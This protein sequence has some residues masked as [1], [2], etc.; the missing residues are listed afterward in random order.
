MSA[1]ML[2]MGGEETGGTT[3]STGP[4]GPTG[5]SGP[6]LEYIVADESHVFPAQAGYRELGAGDSIEKCRKLAYDANYAAFGFRKGLNS[7]WAIV[8]GEDAKD[9][10]KPLAAHVVG[11][12]TKGEDIKKGCATTKDNVLRAR[13]LPNITAAENFSCNSIDSCRAAAKAK[14]ANHFGWR[15]ANNTGWVVTDPAIN[16]LT[17]DFLINHTMGCTDPT[18]KFPNGC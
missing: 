10:V 15:E 13:H 12:V 3:G 8:N 17:T 9:N 6:A 4:T 1:G 11:C 16:T 18:K 2:M 5:P 14:G 7:C